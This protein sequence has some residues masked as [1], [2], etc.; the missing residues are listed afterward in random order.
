MTTRPLDVAATTARRVYYDPKYP[1]LA[2][3]AASGIFGTVILTACQ[4]GRGTPVNVYC[5][6]P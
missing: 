4:P 3:I 6:G 2:R 1:G 5:N